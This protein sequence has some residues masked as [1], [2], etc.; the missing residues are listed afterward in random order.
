MNTGWI[1]CPFCAKIRIAKAEQIQKGCH[2]Q[3]LTCGK[4]W[5]E[6]SHTINLNK[7][8]ENGYIKP[9]IK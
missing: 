5:A 9:R 4:C 6:P 7:H 3:C 2:F 1:S 8:G